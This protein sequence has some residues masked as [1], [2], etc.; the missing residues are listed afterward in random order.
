MKYLTSLFIILGVLLSSCHKNDEPP[1]EIPL[2]IKRNYLPETVAFLKNDNDEAERFKEFSGKQFIVNNLKEMP[3]DPI[4]FS[5]AFG[6]V[7]FTRYTLLIVYSTNVWEFETYYNSFYFDTT[8]R[9]YHWVR[10]LGV[11]TKPDSSSEELH[12]TRFA[13]LV[14]K[15]P[16][17]ANVEFSYSLSSLNWSWD[18]EDRD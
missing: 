5:N 15:L 12:F 7:D 3:A 10:Y 14:D 4:G 13:I 17:D 2:S 1:K 11:A 6:G 16:A 8:E 18:E 9:K